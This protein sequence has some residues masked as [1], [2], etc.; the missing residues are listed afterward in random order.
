MELCPS[1]CDPDQYKQIRRATGVWK[2]Q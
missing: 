1:G 2:S